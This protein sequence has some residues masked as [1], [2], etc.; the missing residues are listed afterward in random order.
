[1]ELIRDAAGCPAVSVPQV[2]AE[3]EPTRLAR[4]TKQTA[5]LR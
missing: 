5:T 4:C 2:L 3:P 1:V